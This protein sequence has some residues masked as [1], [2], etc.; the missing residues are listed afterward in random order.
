M[1][2]NQYVVAAASQHKDIERMQSASLAALQE[3]DELYLVHLFEDPNLCAMHDK[4]VTIMQKTLFGA[5]NQR[6]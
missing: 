4:R 6:Q 5:S 1:S 2:K 3:A